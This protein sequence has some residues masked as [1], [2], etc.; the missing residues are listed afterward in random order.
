MPIRWLNSMLIS[1]QNMLKIHQFYFT[2]MNQAT[3]YQNIGYIISVGLQ[4]GPFMLI[5]KQAT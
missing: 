3:L 2:T 1:N 5:S 4:S